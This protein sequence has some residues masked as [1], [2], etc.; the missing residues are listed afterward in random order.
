M[1]FPSLL[2]LV[3]IV[4]DDSRAFGVQQYDKQMIA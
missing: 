4:G 3:A 1:Y 2:M